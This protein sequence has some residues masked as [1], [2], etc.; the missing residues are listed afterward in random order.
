MSIGPEH[1]NGGRDAAVAH[2]DRASADYRRRYAEAVA[3]TPA[4]ESVKMRAPDN[5]TGSFCHR[6]GFTYHVDA[7]GAVIAVHRKITQ[8]REIDPDFEV[9]GG[10]TQTHATNH[11]AEMI[12]LGFTLVN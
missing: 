8:L 9:A 10:L 12:G 5:V 4:F 7:P 6:D 1:V 2:H 3:T 11:I